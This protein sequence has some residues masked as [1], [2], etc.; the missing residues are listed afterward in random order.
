LNARLGSILIAVSAVAELD[1]D[2]ETRTSM[3]TTAAEETT[4]AAG[5]LAGIA[6]LTACALDESSSDRCDLTEALA[7]ATATARLF[8]IEVDTAD[9][10]AE[11][12]VANPARVDAVLPALLRLVAGASKAVDVRVFPEAGRTHVHLARHDIE[13]DPEAIPP[14]AGYLIEELGARAEDSD[15]LAFSLEASN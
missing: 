1:L 2:A 15:G 6:A 4:R 13:T 7:V 9:I 11:S 5:E 12:V 10:K 8:G 3:L 14:V